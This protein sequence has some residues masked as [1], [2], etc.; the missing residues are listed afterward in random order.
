MKLK[1][2]F[3]YWGLVSVL[4]I[5][6]FQA[7]ILNLPVVIPIYLTCVFVIGVVFYLS[8]RLLL[9]ISFL[10][11]IWNGLFF[12][13]QLLLVLTHFVSGLGFL[14][15]FIFAGIEWIRLYF[16]KKL[17]DDNRRIKQFEEQS[18]HMNET[19]RLV[20]SERH[21][22]LKHISAIHFLLEK[23][24]FGQAKAYLS[25]LVEGYE[26]TNLS[27]K[28]EKGV[29]AGILNQMYRRAKDS[30]IS[31]VYD[32]DLP[33][34][35]LPLTDQELVT[36]L[37]NLL[38]NSLDACE[39]W[40]ALHK[41]QGFVTLQF[42]KRGGLYI[43]TCSNSSLPIPTEILDELFHTHGKT[44]KQHGHEGLGTKMIQDIVKHHNGFLDFVYKDEEF[45]L[46][47][48]MPAIQ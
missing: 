42:Y 2:A 16:A 28:G 34:S 6:H 29:V 31:A 48:K 47:I 20:R 10:G 7:L 26:E 46:K 4:G 23:D 13:L 22:F 9:R 33:V 27:I 45:T 15:L 30:G 24:E 11:V 12:L 41:R 32:L 14:Q 1:S 8:R 3:Y 21:D 39:E 18:A 37:G 44:T 5:I 36:L 35:T 43:L 38:S 40:Q 25:G 17:A 19:F